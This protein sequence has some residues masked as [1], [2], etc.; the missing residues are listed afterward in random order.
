MAILMPM[1]YF[2]TGSLAESI[3]VAV[4]FTVIRLVLYYFHERFWE[5]VHWGREVHP[6]SKIPLS[7]DPTARDMEIIKD[8]LRELGRV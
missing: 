8:K 3:S 1:I 4:T 7:S 6:L 5:G 2:V